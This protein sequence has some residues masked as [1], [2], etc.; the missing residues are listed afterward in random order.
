MWA[1]H[2]ESICL[3]T[4]K[5][6][7]LK[8]LYFGAFNSIRVKFFRKFQYCKLVENGHKIKRPF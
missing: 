8:L 6:K 7:K 2:I 3:F 4:N 5:N 1:N